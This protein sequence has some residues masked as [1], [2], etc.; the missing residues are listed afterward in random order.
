MLLRDSD[1]DG[2]PDGVAA[3]LT[4]DD[5]LESCAGALDVAARLG[6]EASGLTLPLAGDFAVRVGV[7]SLGPG[8]PVGPGLGLIAAAGDRELLVT[9]ADPAG[10]LRAARYLAAR[11][12]FLHGVGTGAP[13]V[14]AG[15]TALLVDGGG[16][17]QVCT[18]GVWV[19][20]GTAAVDGSPQ[21]CEGGALSSLAE[22]YT[23]RAAVSIGLTPALSRA[24]REALVGLA[25][26]FGVEATSLRFPVAVLPGEKDRIG[27]AVSVGGPGS[28]GSGDTVRLTAGDVVITGAAAIAYLAGTPDLGRTLR[29]ALPGPPPIAAEEP[30]A[31][32]AYAGEWE[33]DRFRRVWRE[34]VLPT[35]EPGRPAKVDLRLSEP[36]EVR[37]ALRTELLAQLPPGSDV[38]V[39]SCFKQGLHW[40]ME[41]M[42]PALRQAGPVARCELRF[43]RFT[44]GGDGSRGGASQ[45]AG[46]LDLPIRW[47]QECYPADSLLAQELGI[48][49]ADVAF[50]MTDEGSTYTLTAYDAAGRVLLSGSCECQTGRRLYL[51]AFPERGWV[52][53]P[54]G[55]LM[56]NGRA[57]GPLP[58]DAEACWDWYQTTV[59]PAVRR[60]VTGEF[61][62]SPDLGAQPFFG[63][64]AIHVRMSE[65]DRRL[66]V[67]EEHIS[68]LDAL[69]EDLYFVTLDYLATWGRQLHG[70]P[71]GAPGTILPFV[72]AGG[73]QP[74]AARVTLTR[75]RAAAAAPPPAPV[76]E[77][78]LGVA[79]V[80]TEL[81][82]A[83][84]RRVELGP[85][86]GR[87]AAAPA[88]GA[89]IPL[90]E[91][92]GPEQLPALLAY[93]ES[94]PG[95][96]VWQAGASYLGRPCYGVEL[97]L[98]VPEQI[99][100]PAKAAALK[101]VLLINARHHANEVS[102]T[103][104]VLKT[105]QRAATGDPELVRLLRGAN[106][107]INPL[108]NMDG[109]ATHYA[110]MA[111]H[112]T[113][114]LHAAR[115]NAVGLEFYGQY[116]NPETPY[117]E[118]RVLPELFRE[119]RPDVLLDDHGVPSHEWL[120]PFA[121][122]SSAPYF[123][124]SYWLPN[125]LI[126]GIFRDLDPE[127]YP[128]Q[129]AA[130]HAL[131][132]VLTRRV[133]EAPEIHAWNQAWLDIYSRWGTAWV[134]EK[135]PQELHDGMIC[136]TS[137]AGPNAFSVRFPETCVVDWITE[138]PDETAGGDYL[139]LVAEAHMTGH[140]A[141]LEFLAAHPQ[142]VL[143]SA[144]PEGDG[145]RRRIGRARPFVTVSG[146]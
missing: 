53:P 114:K 96:R 122:Y 63:T 89:D 47:L 134:P 100:P 118:A 52:H 95:V 99:Q 97:R 25:A 85:A 141:C 117:T 59:L 82:L 61:G 55:S 35:L 107:V 70:Q 66:G 54:T 115:F 60:L 77:I 73:G 44:E 38:Q 143:R 137:P 71:F 120:Q 75:R 105:V 101:P 98:P 108:E 83:D 74:P 50:A 90:G 93:L 64:L 123:K 31:D 12:P 133:R 121:G 80:L 76:V 42:L 27:L 104:A 109:A 17:V 69:H 124:V 21:A 11:Y 92:V 1:G 15:A 26:R 68:P 79:G 9:G 131:R 113:W 146:S 24:E 28:S 29:A 138:V 84:G 49:P 126:Y 140:L 130:T 34:Q 36:A 32:L 111:E 40:I 145:I 37:S 41:E 103:N 88:P 23:D 30:Y 14:P 67:R 142:P 106:V 119:F 2:I 136:Y 4:F 10:V 39:R 112:P 51:D 7:G 128:H 22:L 72:S 81:G 57:F 86:D 87:Q 46:G 43:R 5:N 3:A 56:V 65:E 127:Q 33:V 132:A 102:S 45:E 144:A 135:F 62:E 129:V 19:S 78:R 125:A 116:A 20:V 58:T 91:V 16:V 139:R 13:V 94:L 48:R 110:M 8:V 18:G 6:L